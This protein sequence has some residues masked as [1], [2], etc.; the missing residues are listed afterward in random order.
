MYLYLYVL[1]FLSCSYAFSCAP[2]V[3]KAAAH[4][5]DKFVDTHKN[6]GKKIEI[7][8]FYNDALKRTTKRFQFQGIFSKLWGYF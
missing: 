2:I 7:Y 5:E 8:L 3:T 6:F 1:I 4:R